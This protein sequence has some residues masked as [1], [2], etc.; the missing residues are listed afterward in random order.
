VL[1]Q[2]DQPEGGNSS[3]RSHNKFDA[4]T[5]KGSADLYF[6]YYGMLQHQ[7][8]ML[9]DMTRTG[10]YHA[11]I[12]ENRADFEGKV[13]MDVGAGSGILSLFA[14]QVGVWQLVRWVCGGQHLR[15][16]LPGEVCTSK[17]R[18][19]CAGLLF[20]RKRLWIRQQ[21]RAGVLPVEW[22]QH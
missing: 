1:P 4:K 10:T 9:Q 6:H 18:A 13:V 12:T 16:G 20:S 22:R 7:Q 15:Q 3:S 2:Q 11:A 14:A 21:V 5:D 8:N 19:A 17:Q